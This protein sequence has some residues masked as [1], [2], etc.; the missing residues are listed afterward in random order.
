MLLACRQRE[1]ECALAVDISRQPHYPAGH[2]PG[3]I[4]AAGEYAVDRPARSRPDAERLTLPHYD[5]RA[6]V[7]GWLDYPERDCINSDDEGRL[8]ADDSLEL[9]Q[10]RIQNPER[11]RLL[12]V[13]RTATGGGGGRFHVYVA[14]SQVLEHPDLD[15]APLG[16]VAYH[17]EPVR[18]DEHRDVDD[19]LLAGLATVD[20]HS[21]CDSLGRCGRGVVHRDVRH[22]QPDEFTDHGLELPHRLQ[23]A[24]ADLRLV[25]SVGSQE[26][27]ACGKHAYHRGNVIPG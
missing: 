11:A 25:G 21:A 9:H 19:T 20:P 18:R 22:R 7:P 17:L 10:P 4:L 12:D 8:V 5:V 27:T 2:L 3:V 1:C 26:L 15:S 16:I 6:P 23:H 13:Y 24:L 14:I